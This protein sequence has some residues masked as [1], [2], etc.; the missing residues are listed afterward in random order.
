M[1][2]KRSYPET[3][4]SPG[5]PSKKRKVLT[6]GEKIKVIQD[7]DGGLSQRA[8]ATKYGCGRTQIH[9]I[10]AE[11]ETIQS[12]FREGTNSKVKYLQPRNLKYGP[13]DQRVYDFF[14][15]AR[16]KNIPVTGAYLQ[17]HAHIVSLELGYDSFSASNGWLESFISRHQL[18]LAS[19]HGESAEVSEEA[20]QQWMENLPSLLAGYELDDI[21]NCDETGIFFRS[22]PTRSLIREGESAKGVKTLKQRFT[23]LVT[24]SATGKKEKLWIIGHTKKPHSFPKNASDYHN[25][26][27]YR[28]NAKAW[29]TTS[30]FKEYLNW[31]NNRM[32]TKGRKILLLMDNCPAHPPISLTNVNV[33]FLPKNTT[34]VLQPMDAGVIAWV[35]NRYKRLMMTH[36]VEVMDQASDVTSLAKKITI[37]DAVVYLKS[38]WDQIQS[39]TIAKCFRKCGIASDPMC[40]P[41]SSGE[42][43]EDTNSYDERFK[44]ILEVPWQE[45]LAHD[46]TMQA[47]NPCRAPGSY[48]DSDEPDTTEADEEPTETQPIISANTA[49]QYLKDLQKYS[50]NNQ[51]GFDLVNQLIS[52]VRT[53]VIHTELNR[54]TKQSSITDFIK[55]P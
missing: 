55:K 29:M 17:R 15:E 16:A 48:F 25:A 38:A 47:E 46:D 3:F 51:R 19:L 41:P 37:W 35:K 1:A 12:A 7:I 27:K 44:D 26:F 11:K 28:F 5:T 34:A 13:L 53:D 24:A 45:Y 6:L 43:I 23:A 9:N 52:I 36:I 40:T 21:Y 33:V 20:C 18:K 22:V 14:C 10:L 49:L 30:I 42:E 4:G 54:S 32:L 31:L 39:E 8:A 50:M 2:T